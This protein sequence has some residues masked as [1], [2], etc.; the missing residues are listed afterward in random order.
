MATLGPM[1]DACVYCRAKNSADVTRESPLSLVGIRARYAQM[2][3]VSMLFW[4]L[5]NMVYVFSTCEVCIIWL[6]PIAACKIHF[7]SPKRRLEARGLEVTDGLTKML[8][9]GR[10]LI[11]QS[12][13]KTP[14]K[15]QKHQKTG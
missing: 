13:G 2:N 9:H 4:L 1:Y 3:V 5:P 14:V 15:S 10:D 12:T 7:R 8:A 6:K 11:V